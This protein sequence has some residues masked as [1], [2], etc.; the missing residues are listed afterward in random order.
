DVSLCQAFGR[1]GCAEQSVVQDTLDAC[2]EENV[3]QMQQAL[4]QI[5]RHH[6]QAYRHNYQAAWQLL[7]IDLSGR[8]CGP[9]AQEATKGYFARQKSRRGR[10]EGRVYASLYNETVCVRLF[11]GN[12]NTSRAV[13]PL[14]QAA[15]ET[16]GLSVAQ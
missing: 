16:L 7:D 13:T 11:A 1:S 2:T 15:Q 12:T 9:C 4:N 10:Q 8:V 3:V 5:F 14:V 6:S